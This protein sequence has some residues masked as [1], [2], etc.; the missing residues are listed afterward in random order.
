MN[1]LSMMVPAELGNVRRLAVHEALITGLRGA[2]SSPIVRAACVR[3]FWEYVRKKFEGVEEVVVLLE[4]QSQ[5]DNVT[6]GIEGVLGFVFECGFEVDCESPEQRLRDGLEKGLRFV[7][8]SSGWKPTR[9]DVLRFPRDKSGSGT[10]GWPEELLEGQC[11]DIAN[12]RS[13]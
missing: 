11:C 5:Q 8:E 10:E 6:I 13:R 1:A 3:E 12:K 4:R 9:W 7:E 2:S